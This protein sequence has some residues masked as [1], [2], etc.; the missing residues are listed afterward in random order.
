MQSQ[1]QR[2]DLVPPFAATPDEAIK[3]KW[4]I[5]F[6]R[7]RKYRPC[8]TAAVASRVPHRIATLECHYGDGRECECIRATEERATLVRKTA[9]LRDS[10]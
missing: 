8:D 6:S 2:L 9:L 4:R 7:T 1:R 5:S 3:Q 10:E